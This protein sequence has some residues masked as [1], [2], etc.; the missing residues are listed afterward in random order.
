MTIDETTCRSREYKRKPSGKTI[1]CTGD[2]HSNPF[3]DHCLQCAPGWGEI[4][5]LEPVDIDEA[6]EGKLDIR[7]R[8]LDEHQEKVM[9]DHRR[10]GEVS[11][12]TVRRR[13]RRGH[14]TYLVWR[15]T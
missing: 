8:D 7:P 1:P 4:P 3:I 11:L 15:W 14:Q 2:A 5:V 13:V 9:Q 12:V 6:R 10:R